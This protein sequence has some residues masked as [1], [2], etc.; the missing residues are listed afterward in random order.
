MSAQ[1][2]LL[3]LSVAS[4]VLFGINTRSP[5]SLGRTVAKTSATALLAA[6]AALRGGSE[7]SALLPLALGLGAVGDAF[8]SWSDGDGVFL[9]GL[10]N[11]LVA[12]VLYAKLFVDQQPGGH[13]GGFPQM[14]LLLGETWRV[15]VAGLMGLAAPGFAAVLLPRVGRGLR[16]PVAVYSAVIT[17]MFACALTAVEST[18]VVAGTLLFTASDM[19]LASDR[20]LVSADSVHRPWMQYAVWTLYYSGQ[21]LIALGSTG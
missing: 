9:A 3:A 10:A 4:S 2:V 15:F 13:G 17:A 20:F 19:I 21:L 6:L 7:G 8:L 11:F 12:H 5:R 14:S 1:D 18:Q 16:V